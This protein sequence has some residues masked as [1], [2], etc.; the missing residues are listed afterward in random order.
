MADR[1]LVL[2]TEPLAD[3]AVQWLSQCCDVVQCDADD[4]R[5]D[6]LLECTDGLI[7]R[8][9]LRVDSELLY[10]APKLR[11]VG[12]AGIGL[13]TVDVAA[14]R[15]RNV[16]V[17]YTPGAS[18]TAVVEYVIALL[19]DA[20]RPRQALHEA[21]DA[22]QW[23]DVRRR[24][25][26]RRELAESTVGILGF[27]RIGQRLAQ[28]LRGFGCQVVYHD[29][30]E[31]AER[32]RSNAEP[33]DLHTL[34]SNCDVLSVHVDGRSSNR[35]LIR[36]EFLSRMRDD[37]V[38][39]NTSRGM[40]VSADALAEAMRRRP[41][42]RALLDVHEPEPVPADSPLLGLPNVTLL[43]HLAS[44]TDRGLVNMSW[45]VRDIEAVLSGREPEF[46]APCP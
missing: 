41:G 13:D 7:V 36:T 11:V 5:F 6:E 9:Y 15:A 26:G 19:F 10:K 22:A 25:V 4:A 18:T 43:P 31:I 27:G 20:I 17:V 35:N 8:T 1:S 33:V 42:A 34:F 29:V 37:V 21:V 16:E 28:A 24:F 44:R 38:F 40:V 23:W 45:V 3:E 14:C 30:L 39:I 46:P 12:R 2:Y 32:D